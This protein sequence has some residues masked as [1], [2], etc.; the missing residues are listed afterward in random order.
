MTEDASNA[1]ETSQPRS[2]LRL[3]TLIPLAIF[4]AMSIM[5]ALALSSGD[6]S[7]I[8]S[9]LIGK[10]APDM[11][12]GTLEGLERDGKPVPA[13]RAADLSN[14]KVTVVNFWASWCV[15]CRQEHPA[16][17]QIS[18]QTGAQIFGVNYKDP[19][20]GGLRFLKQLG[21]PFDKVGVDPKGR[22]AIEWGVYGMPE[23]F[24]VDGKGIIVY[25]HVGPITPKDLAT[26]I[27][28]AI[29]KAEAAAAS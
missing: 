7:K 24:I 27:I 22:T 8:P 20:G 18:K 25:K 19:G 13:F 23:T 4:T 15:P 11:P 14:G 1:N 21:N 12:L 10:P 17:E 16:F 6:P 3:G 26:K 29:K 2:W 9:A 28:P 5:F